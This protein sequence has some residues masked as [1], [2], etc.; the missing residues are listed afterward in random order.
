MSIPKPIGDKNF[1]QK[2]I[3][4]NPRFENTHSTLDTGT[5]L[6]QHGQMVHKYSTGRSQFTTTNVN[7]N[8]SPGLK[9]DH[10]YYGRIR[11]SEFLQKVIPFPNTSP[12]RGLSPMLPSESSPSPQSPPFLIVDVREG[13]VPFQLPGAVRY[14]LAQLNHSTMPFPISMFKTMKHPE[15][16]F[17]LVDDHED[18]LC[19]GHNHNANRFVE[20]GVARVYV[21]NKGLANLMEKFGEV[22]TS[23]MQGVPLEDVHSMLELKVNQYR[24]QRGVVHGSQTSCCSSRMS[25]SGVDGVR[26]TKGLSSSLAKSNHPGNESFTQKAWK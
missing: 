16:I 11:A 5:I 22:V 1:L 2:R 10:S 12:L 26:K 8:M 25:E 3:P 24:L 9:D 15:G 21:L 6:V 19:S 20:K 18:L 7:T 23:W 17:Y 4:Q 14:N 13:E